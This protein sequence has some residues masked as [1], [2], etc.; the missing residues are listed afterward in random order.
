MFGLI[1]VIVGLYIEYIKDVLYM[2]AIRIRHA[3][4]E[5]ASLDAL[6]AMHMGFVRV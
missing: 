4:H 5:N 6:R 1:A 2:L 3:L